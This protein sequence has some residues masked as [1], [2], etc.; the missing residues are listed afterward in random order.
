MNMWPPFSIESFRVGNPT[1]TVRAIVSA[2][3]MMNTLPTWLNSNVNL[4]PLTGNSDN[5]DHR[6]YGH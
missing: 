1:N 6:S 3:Q 4:V 2:T 5:L